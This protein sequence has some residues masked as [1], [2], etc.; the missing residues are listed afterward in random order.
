[1]SREAPEPKPEVDPSNATAACL[2]SAVVLDHELLRRIGGGSYGEDWLA[3]NVMGTYRAVKIVHRQRFEHERPFERE[4]EGIKKFEPVSRSHE[5]LVDVLQIGRND[6]Q[7]YFYYVM[8]LADDAATPR[9]ESASQS[10]IESREGPVA[11]SRLSTHDPLDSYRPKTLNGEVYRRGRLP[12]EECLQLGLSLTK[13]LEHLHKHG[14]I[15]RDI[16]PSNIIFVNGVQKLADIGLVAE[17]GQTLSFVGTEGF[18][19]PEGPGTPQA[20]IYSLGKVL[21]E[22][23]TGKD[24]Q[25]FPEPPSDLGALPERKQ[26]L[27]LNEIISKACAFD[28]RQRYTS[29]QEMHAE[30]ALLQSGKSVKRLRL[31]ERRLSVAIKIGVA[32][33]LLALLAGGGFYTARRTE[34]KVTEQLV[35]LS[36]AHGVREMDDGDLFG[37]LLWFTETL[38]LEQGKPEREAVHRLRIGSVLRQLPKLE[39]IWFLAPRSALGWFSKDGRLFATVSGDAIVQVWDANTLEPVTPPLPQTNGVNRLAFSPDGERLVTAHEDSTARILDVKTG[40]L[41]VPHL[42]HGEQVRAAVFSPDGQ[43]LVTASGNLGRTKAGEACIWDANTGAL[44]IRILEGQ[45]IVNFA[46]FSPDGRLVLTTGTGDSTRL[47][48]AVTG[49][50]IT[51]VLGETNYANGGYVFSGAFSPDGDHV[52]TA[53]YDSYEAR[54]WDTH[55]GAPLTPP[56]RHELMVHSA[57]FSPDGRYVVTGSADHTARVWDA[58]TGQPISPPLLHDNYV[59]HAEFTSDGQRVVTTSWD[60][61]VRIW[62]YRSGRLAVPVLRSGSTTTTVSLSPD[63][64][65][66]LAGSNDGTIRLWS[67]NHGDEAK[68]TVPSSGVGASLTPDGKHLAAGGPDSLSLFDITTGQQKLSLHPLT[69]ASTAGE[70]FGSPT[71]SRDGRRVAIETF[72]RTQTNENLFAFEVRVWDTT[73]CRE[74]SPPLQVSHPPYSGSPFRSYSADLARVLTVQGKAAQVW[75]L[76]TAKALGPPLQESHNLIGAGLSPDGRRVV[77]TTGKLEIRE[78]WAQVWDADTGRKVIPPLKYE[79]YLTRVAFSPDGRRVAVGSL[80]GT[81]HIWTT[82]TGRLVALLSKH[83]DAVSRVEFS[84]DGQR[85]LSSSYDGLAAIWDAQ[86]GT[87]LTPFF[88]DATGTASFNRDGSLVASLDQRRFLQ[89]WDAATGAPVFPAVKQPAQGTRAQLS[90]DGRYLVVGYLDKMARV[91]ELNKD[92]RPVEDLVKLAQLLAGHKLDA[93]GGL[94]P[95]EPTVLSNAW[96]TLRAKYPHQFASPR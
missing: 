71:F 45:Q 94:T 34:K 29:A 58:V 19:P 90:P 84:P 77:T 92:E 66:L 33:V 72:W 22:V 95:L 14:L 51:P 83:N 27:E 67:L 48:D 96:Q 1:M 88:R 56:L 89:I 64:R 38:R 78:R 2:K 46:A 6:E 62:D 15:H 43:R 3:R 28:A 76:A 37:S 13:A 63:G 10:R 68:L 47:W 36:T 49:Q 11:A 30:L 79:R 69:N 52:A 8:E 87:L 54:I 21:Y 5:G 31:L 4:F 7:G 82:E 57:N 16:K 81:V 86:T 65:R 53:G 32:A 91:W 20:D 12:F 50:P 23:S 74:L 80:D 39:R 9:I 75:D 25:D 35:R 18:I 70:I 40:R 44:I 59:G 60:G 26:L 93:N 41:V 55:T 42:K 85:L 24:R 61:I 73:T 17:V